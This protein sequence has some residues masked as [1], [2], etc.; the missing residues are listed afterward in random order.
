MLTSPLERILIQAAV[1]VYYVRG[2][3]GFALLSSC[4]QRGIFPQGMVVLVRYWLTFLNQ[5]LLFIRLAEDQKIIVE[6]FSRKNI[7]R[8]LQ[9]ETNTLSDKILKTIWVLSLHTF[10]NIQNIRF[11]TFRIFCIRFRTFKTYVSEHSASFGTEK[12]SR[13]GHDILMQTRVTTTVRQTAIL[14]ACV[15]RSSRAKMKG[16]L[17]PLEHHGTMHTEGFK[18]DLQLPPIM[19]RGISL[20]SGLKRPLKKFHSGDIRGFNNKTSG[21]VCQ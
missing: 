12:N 9:L 7:L 19:P 5:V 1:L 8:T 4:S 18:E 10:Q 17:K 20:S 13:T 14:E 2:G 15:Y 3:G 6:F 11:R 16:P 21:F